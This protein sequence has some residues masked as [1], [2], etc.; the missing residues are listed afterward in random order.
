VAVLTLALGIGANTAVFT[1]INAL[2]LRMLPV[3]EPQQLVAIGDPSRVHS[4]HNGTPRTDLFSYPLYRE[5]RDHNSVFSSVLASSNINSLRIDINGG[6]EEA[7]GRLVSGNYFETLGVKP[8]LGRTFAE[9]EDRAPGSDPVVV[10]SYAYWQRRFSGN[11]SAV[12]RTVRV[13]NYPFTIVGIAPPGFFGDVVGDRA[14]LWVPMMMEPQVNPGRD[15]LE[16]PNTS[17]L[18][19]MGRLRPG[20]TIEQARTDV[21][22][23]VKQALTETLSTSLSADDRRAMQTRKF[24]VELSP[25]GRGFSRLREEFSTPLLLLMGLVG[26]VLVVACVNV[27]NLLLARAAGRQREIAVRLAIGAGPGRIVR[28]LL[29]EALLLALLGGALGLLLAKWA[30][31]GLVALVNRGSDNP[32]MLNLDWRVLIF[33]GFICVTAGVLF[34]LAPAMQFLN[35]DMVPALKDGIRGSAGASGGSMRRILVSLQIALGVLVLMAAG[36][37]VRSLRK[38]ED[39]DLGYSRD[40]LVLANVDIVASGYKGPAVRSVTLQLL[41][42]L[43]DLPGVRSV[44]VSGNG[45]F[46][47][48]ESS[49]LV[50]VE[51]FSSAKQEDLTTFDDAVGPNYFST[52]GAP[53]ALGREITDQDFRAGAHVAVVNETFAKFYFGGRN[54]LGYKISIQ[55]SRRPN[56]SPYEII[57]VAR[58]VHD[59]GVRA[60]VQRRMYVPLTSETYF[61]VGGPNFELRAVG[62]PRA[63]IQSVRKRIHDLDAN[64]IIEGVDTGGD[65]VADTLTSQALVAKLS[66]LFGALVLLLV[67]VGLYGTMSYGVVARTREIG[68]RIAIGASRWN[69]VWTVAREA[70]IVL[71]IGIAIGVPSGIA[72]TRLF[73]T[74]LFGVGTTDPVSIAVAIAAMIVIS[75]TAVI[76]PARRAMRVDPMVALRYE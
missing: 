66:A 72:V 70:C 31:A 25:G 18:L 17:T 4:W 43:S 53:I 16:T 7:S 67:C 26:L 55:D 65:L 61:G 69:V 63:L 44:T 38:L 50:G 19:L 11:P 59:H 48:S 21:N 71:A 35:A 30:A 41:D 76:V 47:G 3:A 33:T 9:N 73:Q 51:G 39:F 42:S 54:P 24:A 27:A 37:L 60:A 13:N 52:I 15:F 32:I 46:S 74:L 36:L 57:G 29:T 8:A 49:D 68:I 14:D 75:I 2:M 64:L 56:Q 62:N 58:D 12:G 40:Q 20:I 22:L 23:V 34:G 28:Q 1:V 6:S 10:I 5:V 45:L